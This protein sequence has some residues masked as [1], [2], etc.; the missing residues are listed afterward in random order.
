MN[1]ITGRPLKTMGMVTEL[2]PQTLHSHLAI[3]RGRIPNFAKMCSELCSALL[4]L[5]EHGYVHF[6]MKM[7]NIMVASDGRLVLCDFG[8]AQ[9]MDDDGNV[10]SMQPIMGN[11]QVSSVELMLCGTHY[12]CQG[13]A[14]LVLRICF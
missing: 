5:F 4:Y 12:C 10:R 6:D 8:C 13:C 3:T 11:M 1:Q 9:E 2:H 14:L 7:D